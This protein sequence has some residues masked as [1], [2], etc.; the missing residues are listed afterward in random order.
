LLKG[1]RICGDRAGNDQ[2]LFLVA[3]PRGESG[4]RT[5]RMFAVD[6]LQFRALWQFA[7]YSSR[8]FRR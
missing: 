5:G 3:Q 8:G 6:G 4:R 2:S 7:E 1:A